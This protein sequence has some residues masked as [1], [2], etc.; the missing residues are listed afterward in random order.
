MF[1]SIVVPV[2]CVEPYLRQCVDSILAQ[3]FENYEVILVDDGSTDGS[4]QICNSYAAADPRV[5]V[6]HQENRGLSAARNVGIRAAKGD[7]ILLAD[8][9]DF[10]PEPD[11][12]QHLEELIEEK[13]ADV[14]LFRVRAWFEQT[15]RSRIKTEPYRFDILDRFDKNET[16]QHLLS[17]K[18]F[19]V[20]VYSLCVR[21]QLLQEHRLY[22][23][24]GFKSEDY[25]WIL[26]VLRDSE[27]I[28]AS[29]R[30]LYVYRKGRSGS[31]TNSIDLQ[32]VKDLLETA[33]KW[34]KAPGFSDTELKRA[35]SNYAA[36]IYTTALVVSG[37]FSKEKRK[38][39]VKLLK[40]HRDA[41]RGA[42]RMYLRLIRLS[43][44]LLGI[45]F[46]T[47]VL[48]YLYMLKI[49]REYK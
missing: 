21:R 22:F 44:G 17:A 34:S 10:W 18:H 20:G 43:M 31:I 33:S 11:M 12:L 4:P 15:D 36:Y 6:I 19:P 32:H 40:E 38:Q 42:R 28:Y 49:Q 2:Y 41:M 35:V 3:S 8:S 14:V 48:N 37:R 46:T 23:M 30:V 9:D 25:D 45:S 1:F 13:H 7:N 26:S 47:I 39:A 16:L 27:R 24:E 5:R 29:D